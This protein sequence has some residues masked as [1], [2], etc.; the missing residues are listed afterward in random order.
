MEGRFIIFK[1]GGDTVH[2]IRAPNLRHVA[3]N[4]EMLEQERESRRTPLRLPPARDD[5]IDWPFST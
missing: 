5:D 1:F 3:V 2:A 4:R